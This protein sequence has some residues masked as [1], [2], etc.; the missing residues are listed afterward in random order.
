[1]LAIAWIGVLLEF[2]GRLE[3]ARWFLRATFLSFPLGFIAVI[4]G[5]VTAEVGRQ[6]WVVYAVVYSFGFIYIIRL[7]CSGADAPLTVSD[8]SLP[9]LER[10]PS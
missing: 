1:M 6:P 4:C 8:A 5:W 10:Q 9:V 3:R 7:L 2:S